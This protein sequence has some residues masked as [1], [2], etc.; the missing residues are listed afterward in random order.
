ML[1]IASIAMSVALSAQRLRELAKAHAPSRGGGDR[2][3][4]YASGIFEVQDGKVTPL[5]VHGK[6]LF[7]EAF[8]VPLQSVLTRI[9]Q[10]RLH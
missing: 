1:V 3:E 4:P 6:T 2:Y 9:Q 10:A 7:R 5:H 8:D